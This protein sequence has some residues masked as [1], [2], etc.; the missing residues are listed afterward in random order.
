MSERPL[1]IHPRRP[2]RLRPFPH[3]AVQ[4]DDRL[5]ARRGFRGTIAREGKDGPH[6]R[7]GIHV[8]AHHDGAPDRKIIAD[9]QELVASVPA[10]D[11]ADEMPLAYRRPFL[12]GEGVTSLKKHLI[13]AAERGDAEA[14]FNLAVIYENNLVDSRYIAEAFHSEAV[15]WLL[16]AAEQA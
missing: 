14:Q 7:P 15:R 8:V 2:H 5:L 6:I 16:A 13:Q 4:G 11:V 3:A 9:E 1:K 12:K 10:S